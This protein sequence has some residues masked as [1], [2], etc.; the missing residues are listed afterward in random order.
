MKWI[1]H[2]YDFVVQETHLD[3]FGH[4]NNSVYLELFENA[5]WDF[6]DKR[7]FGYKHIHSIQIGPTILEIQLK[8]KKEVKLRMKVRI[9]SQMLSQEGKVGELL[10]EMRDENGELLTEMKMKMGLFDMKARRLIAP[11]PEWLRAIG[12][13]N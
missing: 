11:T 9:E 1:R 8:F 12:L 2:T 7:G 4:M 13:E 5:R 10:Q 3:S 6:I